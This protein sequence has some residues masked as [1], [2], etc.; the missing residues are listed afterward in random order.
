MLRNIIKQDKK[1]LYCISI[2]ME[3]TEENKDEIKIKPKE[4]NL[5]IR[6]SILIIIH[7]KINLFN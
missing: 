6:G 2:T 5:S 7:N 4:I 1:I 3:I